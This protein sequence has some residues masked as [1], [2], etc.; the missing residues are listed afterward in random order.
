[1]TP[2]WNPLAQSAQTRGS[3]TT[4]FR[5]EMYRLL[6]DH[7][8]VRAWNRV[9]AVQSR[10][11]WAAEEVS[12]RMLRGYVCGLDLAPNETESAARLRGVA[13]RIEFKTWDGARF[14]LPNEAFDTVLSCFALNRFP[15]PVA[16]LREMRRVLRPQGRIYLLEPDRSS[17]GGVYQLWDYYF[18]LID[19]GHI[20][21]YSTAQ[22]LAFL[23]D[24]GFVNQRELHRY[25]KFRDPGK[26]LATAVILEGQRSGTDK[27]SQTV[28]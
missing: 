3:R 9:L 8:R 19:E 22:L 16:V 4:E 6:L 24:A 20:R 27:I 1:M 23:Q 7:V 11:G 2:V 17:F 28:E 5:H 18:R 21:Y 25:E 12:R 13:G 10:G 15:Q 14:P 26:A